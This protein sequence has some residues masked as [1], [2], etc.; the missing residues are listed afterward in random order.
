[1][2]GASP[3]GSPSEMFDL[4]KNY[5][6][7]VFGFMGFENIQSVIVEPTLQGGP[8]VASVMRQ[9]SID[10]AKEIALDF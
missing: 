8:Q 4:Q 7:L 5:V 10:K 9:Q 3:V 2:L 1:M 6:E